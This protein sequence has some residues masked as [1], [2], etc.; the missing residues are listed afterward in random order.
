MRIQRAGAPSTPLSLRGRQ[1]I[2][3]SPGLTSSRTS[4]STT[5]M[6]CGMPAK[7]TS[8]RSLVQECWRR[9]KG[10]VPPGLPI[11]ATKEVT[12]RALPSWRPTHLFE[13]RHMRRRE[14]LKPGD[15]KIVNPDCL[16]CRKLGGQEVGAA[17]GQGRV[18]AVK[19]GR[20]HQPPACPSKRQRRGGRSLHMLQEGTTG[21]KDCDR[22]CECCEW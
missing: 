10:G 3:Y 18:R 9:A 8:R 4:P 17:S 7:G 19:L 6:P 20:V 16:Y 12:G 13:Q 15:G 1:A 21:D 11:P 5:I 14:V 2:V 22:R